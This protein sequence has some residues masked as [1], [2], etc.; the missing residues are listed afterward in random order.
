MAKKATRSPT[1]SPPDDPVRAYAEAVLAG[2]VVAG[3]LVR[4]ACKR[5]LADFADGPARGLTW[6]LAAARR[7]IAFFPDVLRLAEGEH[8]GRPFSLEPWQQFIVG[9]LFGWKTADGF[10]RFRT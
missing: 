6:D 3:P 10:R 4:A 8:A 2:L 7:A 5:H 9:S 1:T